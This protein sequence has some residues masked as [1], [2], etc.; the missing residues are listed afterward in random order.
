MTLAI[1]AINRANDEQTSLEL[2]RSGNANSYAHSA[3]VNKEI[4]CG[5]LSE[6]ARTDCEAKE[7]DAARQAEYDERDLLAQQATAIWTR[8]MGAAAILGTAFG[9]L[10]I[11]LVLATF[12]EN[13]RAADAAHDANRPWIEGETPTEVDMELTS[14][15]VKLSADVGL[16]NHG[17]SPAINVLAQARLVA[18]RNIKQQ[19]ENASTISRS[20]I[21]AALDEWE[22]KHGPR[23][24]TIYPTRPDKTVVVAELP[25]DEIRKAEGVP[26]EECIYLLAI[27]ITYRFGGRKGRTVK[28]Y[29]L[30]IRDHPSLLK[31]PYTIAQNL[32]QIVGDAHIIL[33][34]THEGYA[35]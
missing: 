18:I 1:F 12:W 3:N 10:G 5:P 27:G 20:R 17:D 34:D 35:V 29:L 2:E 33:D 19:G 13:K 16:L 15:G 26:P 28:A 4:R 6:Q 30:R 7:D 8:Y 22:R 24:K 9:I 32:T 31:A 11:V 25:I 14:D 23:G 21:E